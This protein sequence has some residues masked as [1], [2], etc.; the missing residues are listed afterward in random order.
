MKV[1]ACILLLLAAAPLACTS[2]PQSLE[3]RARLHGAQAL[4][5]GTPV[6][7]AGAR[8][9]E[10]ISVRPVGFE[11]SEVVFRID[12]S[13]ATRIPSDAT[14]SMHAVEPGEYFLYLHVRGKTGPPAA[15]NQLLSEAAV[16]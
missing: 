3:L 7:L 15:N 14:V 16:R 8:V 10:V 13:K 5:I 11:E 12:N 1:R 6:L 9:G 4:Q 2:K